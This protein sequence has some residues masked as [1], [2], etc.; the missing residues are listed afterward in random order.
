MNQ[1]GSAG[2]PNFR[3]KLY[4]KLIQE[5][6]PKLGRIFDFRLMLRVFNFLEKLE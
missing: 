1:N 2:L 4:Y 5:E 6:G 3:Y